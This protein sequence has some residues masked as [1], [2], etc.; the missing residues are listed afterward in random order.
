MKNLIRN[1]LISFC[2]L[3]SIAPAFGQYKTKKHI[4]RNHKAPTMSCENAAIYSRGLLVEGNK[5]FTGNSDGS[6]Y[7]FNLEKQNVQLLFK[8]DDF[9]EM[10]DIERSGS[11]LIGIQSGDNGKLVLLNTGGG[12]KIVELPEWKGAFFD[13]ISFLGKRGFLMGD[14]MN[15]KF[16]L[17]HSNDGGVSWEPTK[18]SIPAFKGE[19]GF[20]SSGSNVQVINDSTYVFVSGGE[21]SY[22]Y[23]TTD[24]GNN[25]KGVVLPY[26]P[27]E[28]SGAFSV[29]FSSDSIGVIVGGDYQNFDLKLN[30]AYYTTDGGES[31]YNAENE[32]RGYRACTHESNGI[33]YACG[34][35][36]IDFSYDNGINWIPF[37]N[38]AYYS[39]GSNETKLIATTKEGKI[40]I[41]DLIEP[42]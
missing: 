26:Y 37:A 15:G 1:I 10:R 29:H 32:P 28:S 17:Y 25:W 35:N 21:K 6:M 3:L 33:Y 5:I 7:Y 9:V 42:K 36:G 8:L 23:K 39:L 13:G 31:W 16:M 41:F 19:A 14:P 20:A 22:F 2:F 38:G 4:K 11:N 40:Q 27:G 18:A 24:N 12:A 34:R 30:T